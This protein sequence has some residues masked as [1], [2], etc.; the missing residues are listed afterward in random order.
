MDLKNYAQIW[1]SDDNLKLDVEKDNSTSFWHSCASL[2]PNLKSVPYESYD[3][4]HD[5]ILRHLQ[6]NPIAVKDKKNWT[7]TQVHELVNRQVI[8]WKNFGLAP[9]HAV[10]LV[11]PKGI[12]FIVALMTALR[13]GL[14]ITILSLNDSYLGKHKLE[15]ILKKQSFDAIV[16]PSSTLFVGKKVLEWNLD[17]PSS[18]NIDTSSYVYSSSSQAFSFLNTDDAFL[19]P[20]RDGYIILGLREGTVWAHPLSSP[21]QNEPF[22]TLTTLLSGATLFHIDDAALL[23]DPTSL[24]NTDIEILEV[25]S[26]LIDL[27]KQTPGCPQSKLRLWYK[28][29]LL[30]NLSDWNQFNNQN[31]LKNV[32]FSD[33]YIDPSAG[34]II[35]ASKPKP[36]SGQSFLFPPLGTNWK[37]LDLNNTGEETI[38]G[39]GYYSLK[40]SLILGQVQDTWVISWSTTPIYKGTFYPS[41]AVEQ[42]VDK[43]PFISACM[44]IGERDPKDLVSSQITLLL[45]INNENK[46]LEIEDWKIQ[47]HE[48]IK[49]EIGEAFLP[50]R[51]LPFTFYPNR[52]DG[53][54][55]RNWVLGQYHSGLLY[56]KQHSPLY[57]QFNLFKHALYQT[58]LKH[59]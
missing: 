57:Y 50:N 55:N 37:I 21:M 46:A 14:C 32:S 3:F 33:L 24:K 49:Q 17:I 27:W 40:P 25:S 22:S 53:K 11:V 44:V 19:N 10:A 30:G 18:G 45:F 56:R 36:Y 41:E 4:Y 42:C 47:I 48:A 12:D 35:F 1:W 6:K 34:G 38:E 26:S 29:P 28:S 23:N 15:K 39:V 8:L 54:L 58:L 43:L 7:Y 13:I 52:L 31:N 59:D 2:Y 51:I 9:G 16:I 20:L 5:C